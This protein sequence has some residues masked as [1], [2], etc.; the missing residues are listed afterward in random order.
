[1][2]LELGLRALLG[3]G[4]GDVSVVAAVQLLDQAEGSGAATLESLSPEAYLLCAERAIEAG[5]ADL[6]RKAAE[7][8]LNKSPAKDQFLARAYFVLGRVQ[9]AECA[10]LKA[11]TRLSALG[12]A[13]AQVQ[14][15]I[16]LG[17]AL[18][19]EHSFLVYN[20][21]VLLWS[22]AKGLVGQRSAGASAALQDVLAAALKSLAAVGE[23]DAEWRLRLTTHQA[24]AMAAA[25][26]VA[27]AIALLASPA[28]QGSIKDV[29]RPAADELVM[30]QA[31]LLAADPAGLKKL[32]DAH[33]ASSRRAAML[34]AQALRDGASRASS[35]G[36]ASAAET[37]AALAEL[38]GAVETLDPALAAALRTEGGEQPIRKAVAALP[39]S[40]GEAE[41]L[42][43]LACV[44]AERRLLDVASGLAQRV[45]S[46]AELGPRTRAALVQQAIRVARLDAE[47][48]TFTRRMVSVRVEAVRGME[49]LLSPARRAESLELIQD[50][51]VYM[52]NVALPLLQPSLLPLVAP[53]LEMAASA[54]EEIGSPLLQLR[55]NLHLELA[56]RD[57]SAD[58]VSKASAHVS[59]A[60]SLDCPCDG[61]G[62]RPLDEPLLQLQRRLA[63]KL[64]TFDL[65]SSSEQEALGLLDQIRTAAPTLKKQLCV[66]LHELLAASEPAAV[67]SV[68]VDGEAGAA[69]ARAAGGGGVL[70]TDTTGTGQ[71]AEAVAADVARERFFLWAELMKQAW[72]ARLRGPARA[73]AAAVLAVPLSTNPVTDRERVRLQAEARFVNA[74]TFIDELHGKEVA[75]AAAGTEGKDG[76]TAWAEAEL[77]GLRASALGEMEAGMQLGLALKED[78]LVYNGCIYLWNYNQPLLKARDLEPLLPAMRAGV[79]AMKATNQAELARELPL[80]KLACALAAAYTR[81]LEVHATAPPAAAGDRRTHD[82]KNTAQVAALRAAEEA[83]RWASDLAGNRHRLKRGVTGCWARLQAAAGAKEPSVGV[84]AEAAA[85]GR[86]ELLAARLVD[87]SARG[88]MLAKAK[89]LLLSGG[90]DGGPIVD[91]E[92]W[93]RCAQQSLALGDLA[94][95]VEGC[96]R[97]LAP[98]RAQEAGRPPLRDEWRWYALAEFVQGDAMEHLLS[99][100][101]APSLRAQLHAQ[102]AAHLSTAMEHATAA[103]EVG[104]LLTAASRL[105]Q[106]CGPFSDAPRATGGVAVALIRPT[107]GRAL[108]VLEGLDTAEQPRVQALRV[109]LYRLQL[110][111]LAEEREWGEGI[112]LLRRA[113]ATLPRSCHQPLW[114]Q[115]VRF[116]CLG[117]STRLAGEM[118]QLK[119]FEPEAQAEIWAALAT[120][121][122][123]AG[124]QLHALLRASEVLTSQPRL[125]VGALIALGEWLF[126]NGFPTRDAEDQLLAA[127]DMLTEAEDDSMADAD[128]DGES[129]AEDGGS[130]IVSSGSA[131]RPRGSSSSVAT[132]AALSTRSGG[133]Q[134]AGGADDG[135]LTVLQLE[136]LSRVYVM[137]ARMA[138]T[139]AARTENLLVSCHY[140]QRIWA[141]SAATAAALEAAGS[142]PAGLPPADE[143]DAGGEGAAYTVPT[144]PHEWAT[145]VPPRR[146]AAILRDC[147][148][149]SA[150]CGRSVPQPYLSA[151]YLEYAAEAL[152]EAGLVLHA[153]LPLSLLRQLASAVACDA[154]L[155]LLAAL[156]QARLLRSLGLADEADAIVTALPSL[157]PTPQQKRENAAKL[158]LARQAPTHEALAA[159]PPS[160]GANLF[161]PKKPQPRSARRPDAAVWV[162]IAS[163]LADDAE[164]TAA[165]AWLA[166]ARPS[167][168]ALGDGSG[169]AVCSLV[170]A[171]LASDRG[172]AAA[173]ISLL[174]RAL[175]LPLDVGEWASA[176]ETL[177]TCSL[178]RGERDAGMRA[179]VDGIRVCG[180][181]AE[182]YPASATQ[183]LVA[184]AELQRALGRA[185]LAEAPAADVA[186]S[187]HRAAAAEAAALFEQAAVTLHAIGAHARATATLLERAE[188]AEAAAA[189]ALRAGAVGAAGDDLALEAE[190]AQLQSVAEALAEAASTAEHVLFSAAP[191]GM[192]PAISLPAARQLAALKRKMAALELSQ[193]AMQA[194]A[195]AAHPPRAAFFPTMSHQS[196]AASAAV[197]IFLYPPTAVPFSAAVPHTDAALLH[198]SGAVA[199]AGPAESHA[200]VRARLAQAGALVAVG[201][202]RGWGVD[203]WAPAPAVE[204]P[205]YAEAMANG[206]ATAA[207]PAE[208]QGD[209]EQ[210]AR[211]PVETMAGAAEAAEGEAG[212]REVV[213]LALAQLDDSP[214]HQAALQL[215]DSAGCARP[216]ECARWLAL[217]HACGARTH[218]MAQWRA[219]CPAGSRF[220]LLLRQLDTLRRQWPRPAACAQWR[221]AVSALDDEA[222]GCA[223]WQ[224][225][226]V[227]EDPLGK[228]LP[229]LSAMP[230]GTRLLLVTRSEDRGTLYGAVI[231]PATDV[232]AAPPAAAPKGK[233]AAPAAAS[234]PP[235]PTPRC[236][237]SRASVSPAAVAAALASTDVARRQLSREA[238]ARST[239]GDLAAAGGGEAALAEALAEFERLLE[240]VLAPLRP[241]FA[242]DPATEGSTETPA[243]ALL[244]PTVVIT[245]ADMAPLPFELL[246]LLRQRHLGCVCRDLSVPLV[247][248]RLSRG[249][250]QAPKSDVGYAVDVRNEICVPAPPLQ[251]T[252]RV[253]KPAGAAPHL[254]PRPLGKAFGEEVLA[255]K[256]AGVGKDWRGGLLGT[257]AAPSATQLQR[258]ISGHQVFFYAGPGSLLSILAPEFAA[259]L[260]LRSSAACLLFDQHQEEGSAR[261]LAKQANSKSAPRLALEEPHATAGLLSLGGVRTVLLHDRGATPADRHADSLRVL[262]GLSSGASLGELVRD[263]YAQ[264][265]EPLTSDAPAASGATREEQFI[266]PREALA[267]LPDTSAILYGLPHFRLV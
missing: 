104:L 160:G 223:A 158:A 94:A 264:A 60:L 103:G 187:S 147:D 177:G 247:G 67:E 184:K 189:A 98:L 48:E 214:A 145:W 91:P 246:A 152:A 83:C 72:S 58:L 197:A 230:A 84:E 129:G 7:R 233:G 198:A 105:W 221:A 267:P 260:D 258:A 188:L 46:A 227:P 261:R 45:S 18:G 263:A 119:S 36:A 168:E 116:M 251:H 43:A 49:S 31:H 224:S 107:V 90:P 216:M 29:P 86:L 14:R 12:Q 26:K 39:G 122:T 228:L 56:R 2:A 204:A 253:G 51:C 25:G 5:R 117:D 259:P 225:L 149:D 52:W 77:A 144:E 200:G 257:D 193:A 75:A 185:I 181:A 143:A 141:Q 115:K 256:A 194:R 73:A 54:L 239:E 234:A 235:P 213:Q 110:A 195:D 205:A 245:D 199:L 97:A 183:A 50:V 211:R 265:K 118:L 23:V 74:E 243:G 70:A 55:A 16:D 222:T 266:T 41:A 226:A 113:F 252:P 93:V 167:L 170:E 196:E 99:P 250:A 120:S 121:S 254:E 124:E 4:E 229:L 201:R 208:P 126:C 190:A 165:A 78:H 22:I 241:A 30:L 40:S 166:E 8:F 133:T 202:E 19:A 108:T 66:Q 180:E 244:P 151:Y 191:R 203:A 53:S 37:E 24:R 137:L 148:A 154:P 169:I 164:W 69:G 262:T 61:S 11:E 176:V 255:G 135:A 217:A 109:Q 136:Q 215:A 206:A 175:E 131:R 163:L 42:A 207:A 157:R 64:D 33:A 10:D 79:E 218:W 111:A 139:A 209:P 92:L 81:A 212:L 13:L 192:P 106:H 178:A 27:D 236:L 173:A 28:V 210:A 44:A 242:P 9:A 248:L 128:E 101:Q 59:K 232:P 6:A 1:M 161:A 82:P 171:R 182:T 146:L 238:L 32:R 38:L 68:V 34:C 142:L 15:G 174:R 100:S 134:A 21:S 237:V 85:Y 159:A 240:P 35:S 127:A 179:L 125:R 76:P 63:V 3:S 231:A 249:V 172:D 47:A 155:E 138:P 112:S 87:A 150:L 96:E 62:L 132:S 153:L 88:P 186:S 71:V 130:S 65:A 17:V 95:V 80:L 89:E 57:A 140:L 114:Q 20:G 220:I 123:K 102:A 162:S 156:K 219:A